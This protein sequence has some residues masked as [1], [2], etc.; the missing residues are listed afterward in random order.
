MVIH[1][2][3]FMY[4]KGNCGIH[5]L[6]FLE[7]HKKIVNFFERDDKL[8]GKTHQRTN[9]KVYIEIDLQMHR[10]GNRHR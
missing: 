7:L 3:P 2:T 8:L 6:S 5:T 9:I 4:V 10:T 1:S